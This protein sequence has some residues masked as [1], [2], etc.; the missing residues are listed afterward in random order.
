MSDNH[1]ANNRSRHI[2]IDRFSQPTW[3]FCVVLDKNARAVRITQ[4]NGL[5]GNSGV[6]TGLA[7]STIV[8]LNRN[9]E[10][11]SKDSTL[12]VVGHFYLSAHKDCDNEKD[13]DDANNNTNIS[14]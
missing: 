9:R 13:T 8:R 7:I 1:F 2:S 14:H 6:T 10:A 3:V 12:V 5:V 4:L 11:I